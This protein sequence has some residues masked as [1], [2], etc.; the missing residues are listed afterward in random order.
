VLVIY[1]PFLQ[2]AFHTVALSATDW[3]VVTGVSAT[4]LVIA[5]LVKL[6]RRMER[7]RASALVAPTDHAQP[8]RVIGTP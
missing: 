2:T 7:A 3:L 5:E 8:W 4:L 1:V 6:V